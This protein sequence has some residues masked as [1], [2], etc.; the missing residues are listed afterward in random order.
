MSGICHNCGT[1]LITAKKSP[2]P[3]KEPTVKK[4][5]TIQEIIIRAIQLCVC[6]IVSVTVS[7][8][9]LAF[10]VRDGGHDAGNIIAIALLFVVPIVSNLA[11][12]FAFW[13]FRKSAFNL[14]CFYSML[15]GTGITWLFAMVVGGIRSLTY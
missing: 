1:P 13:L 8:A 2:T 5:L 15:T 6:Y 7:F 4:D 11:F 12:F 14:R 10:C 9:S 3:P